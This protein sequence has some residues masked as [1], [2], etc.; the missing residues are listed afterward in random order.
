MFNARLY[1][2][3]LVPV[4]IAL[5]VAS[6]SLGPRSLPRGSTLAPDAFRGARA[7]AELQRLAATYPQRRPGSEGDARLA[8]QIAATLRG[9]GGAAGG[10]FTVHVQHGEGQTID[11][12]RPLTTVAAER[13]GSTN[14]TPIV[15]VAHR[16]AA[17][18]GSAA[19]LSGTATLLEL[20]RVFAARETKRTI[21]LVSTSGGS[22]GAAGAAALPGAFASGAAHG[23]VDAAIVV[24]DVAGATTRRPMVLPFSDAYGLAP[25]QLQ[26]TVADA[27][28]REE[29]S[30]PGAP[31]VLGQ[32]AHLALPLTVGEQGVLDAAGI[33]AV[34]VQASGERGPAPR[35]AVAA[36][37]L[38]GLGRGVLSAVDAL[39]VTPDV[40]PAMQT[41]LVL[42]RKL[43]PGWTVQL[44]VGTLLLA[45]L[46]VLVDALA[47]LRR[48]RQPVGR[49][50]LW[51][52]ACA[53]PFL[54]CALLAYVL[55]SL[56]LAPAAPGVLVLPHAL[57]V[58]GTA[59]ALLAVVALAFVLAWLGWAALLRGRGLEVRPDPDVA[60]LSML[61]VLGAVSVVVWI[62]N[63][64]AALLLVPALH[65]WL[66]LASPEL[67]PAR[68]GSAA[69]VAAGLL[70]LVLLLAFYAHQL[71]F[72]PLSL[73]W[74]AFLLVAGGGVGI[75]AVL[76]WSIA[77]GC[78][79]AAVMLVPA[80]GG[81]TPEQLPPELEEITIRGPLTYAGPGSLGGTESALRR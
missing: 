72:S 35:D 71:G 81:T 15:I 7:L 65:L 77:L 52:L 51:T 53:L 20:A 39:D 6:F 32:L 41:G 80:S 68:L 42:Q 10:G 54:L 60:G 2:A 3:A 64:Y 9:L 43:L 5:A 49:W 73:A 17:A 12:K 4:V 58:D 38:E 74:A 67:R 57:P 45:P 23:G 34:M 27:L 1:R 69:L 37:R 28:R 46:L 66:L 22:G 62:A 36:G 18:A 21:V 56:G 48:R 47:R 26:R 40:A 13:P 8:E 11:G 25:L 75:F 19:E 61:L 63:P 79:A 14:A 16:D 59:A 31:S 76:L 24:G 33:P 29:G 70:P 50:T 55:G 78:V 44:V 30:D